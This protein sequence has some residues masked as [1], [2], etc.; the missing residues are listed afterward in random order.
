MLVM[1][2]VETVIEDLL[3]LTED[4]DTGFMDDDNFQSSVF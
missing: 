4:F 2:L 3:V 1:W